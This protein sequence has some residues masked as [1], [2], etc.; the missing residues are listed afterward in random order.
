MLS[1][2]LRI[3]FIESFN[4]S[5]LI[6]W[7]QSP[8]KFI[9]NFLHLIEN[10]LFFVTLILSLRNSFFFFIDFNITIL[11]FFV[12]LKIMVIVECWIICA[13]KISCRTHMV[14]FIIGY[15]MILERDMI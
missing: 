12:L 1:L 5:A 11:C 10:I 6:L 15:L 2:I 9:W 13:F 7:I 8:P 4:I 14:L 3:S